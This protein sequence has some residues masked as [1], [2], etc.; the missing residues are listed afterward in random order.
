MARKLAA[1]IALCLPLTAQLSNVLT[2]NPPPAIPVKKGQ[3]LTVELPVSLRPEYH[4]NSNTPMDEY[5]IPLKLTWEKGAAEALEVLYPK[6]MMEKFQFSS[7]P[8]SVYTG[9]FKIT[10]KFRITTAALP[11]QNLIAGKLRYQACNNKM[12]LPPRSADVKIPIEVR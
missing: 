5:L 3:V 6:P 12:C 8:V 9:Q 2:V 10:T 1:T 4:V 7:K 11:G